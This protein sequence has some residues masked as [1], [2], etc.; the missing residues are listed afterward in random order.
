MPT[1]ELIVNVEV[2]FLDQR[3]RVDESRAHTLQITNQAEFSLNFAKAGAKALG[4]PEAVMSTIVS[5]NN[6]LTFGGTLDPAFSL[7]VTSLDNL[8]S[9]ANE[10]YSATFSD[11]IDSNLGIPKDRGYIIFRDPGREYMGYKGTTFASLW[12]N[13]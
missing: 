4:K 10:K 11:F 1:L 7:T 5:F 12:A 9:E 8:S 2:G 6:S 3:G 13:K